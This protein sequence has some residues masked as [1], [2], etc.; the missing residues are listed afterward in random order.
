MRDFTQST[1]PA[2]VNKTSQVHHYYSDYF[3]STSLH[4]AAYDGNSSAV[5]FLLRAG[6]NSNLTDEEGYASLNHPIMDR[7]NDIEVARL[8]VNYEASPFRGGLTDRNRCVTFT[9]RRTKRN[10]KW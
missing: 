5:Q 9:G 6:A 3:Q 10:T 4:E 2:I 1:S 7:D 8:L